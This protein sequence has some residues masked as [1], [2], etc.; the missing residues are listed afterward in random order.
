MRS[1]MKAIAGFLVTALL[2]ALLVMI[3]VTAGGDVQIA[4]ACRNASV[5]LAS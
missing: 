1:D 4:E 5:R 2:A 3:A